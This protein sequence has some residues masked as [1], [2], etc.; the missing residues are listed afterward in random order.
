[1]NINTPSSAHRNPPP[2]ESARAI[3]PVIPKI[4]VTPPEDDDIFHPLPDRILFHILNDLTDFRDLACTIAASGKMRRVFT[5]HSRIIS[6]NHLVKYLGHDG[7]NDLVAFCQM[8][9]AVCSRRPVSDLEKFMRVWSRNQLLSRDIVPSSARVKMM[10]QFL[11]LMASYIDRMLAQMFHQQAIW[12]EDSG[13]EKQPFYQGATRQIYRVFFL[14]LIACMAYGLRDS[15]IHGQGRKWF[16]SVHWTNIQEASQVIYRLEHCQRDGK[17]DHRSPDLVGKILDMARRARGSPGEAS[18]GSIT[19]PADS[20][21]DI[22]IKNWIESRGPEHP[23]SSAA[24]EGSGQGSNDSEDEFLCGCP[25]CIRCKCRACMD[26]HLREMNSAALT[27]L[28][29]SC[30]GVYE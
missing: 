13:E 14:S 15:R 29:V 21:L 1:M 26:C 20:R 3:K 9:K 8:S 25:W 17:L 4:I 5:F 2:I 23:G 27:A 6:W 10:V 22:T 30:I 11:L 28:L 7:L 24:R 16:S 12:K 19:F 18:T